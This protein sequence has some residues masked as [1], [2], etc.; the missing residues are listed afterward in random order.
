LI[1]RAL[2]LLVG[3]LAA[4]LLLTVAVANR[5]CVRLVLDPFSNTPGESCT[6]V[7]NA[8][9]TV[10]LP[11]YAYLFAMLI[12]GVILG[13]MATYMTQ[14][15]WRKAARHRTQESI[16]WKAEADRLV[17]ERDAAAAS[18]SPISAVQGRRQIALV[19]R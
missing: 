19:G 8:I 12:A 6:T 14:M 18:A 5:H 2:G 3:L 7:S 4:I 17:R 10:D 15:K 1:G 11:F 13:G 9:V 16:R